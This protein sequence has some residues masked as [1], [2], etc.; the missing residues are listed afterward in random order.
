MNDLALNNEDCQ[1]KDI[2]ISRIWTN[3]KAFD[4]VNV[5]NNIY[6]VIDKIEFTVWVKTVSEANNFDPWRKKH[7]RHKMQKRAVAFAFIQ[8]RSDPNREF[9]FKNITLPCT[10]KLTRLSSRFLDEHDNLRM[11]LKY[12]NDQLCAEI[13][14][15]FIP[16]RADNYEGFTFEYAQEKSKKQGVKIEITY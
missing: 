4:S 1:K 3:L 10:V 2:K 16:G 9:R 7:Q 13:T 6:K 15:N 8:G 5:E 11:A 12:I 14:Q